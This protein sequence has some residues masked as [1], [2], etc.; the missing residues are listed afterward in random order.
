MI[1]I[2]SRALTAMAAVFLSPVTSLAGADS[3]QMPAAGAPKSTRN[4]VAADDVEW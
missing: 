1:R 4:Y 3:A 2:L